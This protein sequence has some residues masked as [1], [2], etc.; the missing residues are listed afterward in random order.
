MARDRSH[1]ILDFA[2]LCNITDLSHFELKMSTDLQYSINKNPRLSRH[3]STSNGS[4]NAGSP[5]PDQESQASKPNGTKVRTKPDYPPRPE[6]RPTHLLGR[7]KG[8]I[9]VAPA[10][11]HIPIDTSLPSLVFPDG[12]RVARPN[13]FRPPYLTE[14][15]ARHLSIHIND[16]Y[17][18]TRSIELFGSPRSA[19]WVANL[20][21]G[22]SRGTITNRTNEFLQ[23]L[24][25]SHAGVKPFSDEAW[26]E[27]LV[28]KQNPRIRYGPDDHEFQEIKPP[29]MALGYTI[30]P[31]HKSQLEFVRRTGHAQRLSPSFSRFVRQQNYPR[32]KRIDRFY[33]W[34]SHLIVVFASPAARRAI[35]AA[36]AWWIRRKLLDAYEEDEKPDQPAFLPPVGAEELV[37]GGVKVEDD[38]HAAL[39][40]AKQVGWRPEYRIRPYQGRRKKND[41]G[42]GWYDSE[43]ETRLRIR[44][45]RRE[46]EERLQRERAERAERRGRKNEE[47][48]NVESE[49]QA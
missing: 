42:E 21:V 1:L 48:R 44:N 10:S 26:A 25:W 12:T 4:D 7:T 19:G 11:A 6:K 31:E 36:Y 28:A 20:T 15:L 22:A 38:V 27:H 39:D 14:R 29:S 23:A 33:S 47:A 8:L 2:F 37:V 3:N 43:I 49:T 45:K 32:P 30:A 41:H 17:V 18:I 16:P 46:L 40:W 35:L 5:L 34:D 24:P 13:A 9:R